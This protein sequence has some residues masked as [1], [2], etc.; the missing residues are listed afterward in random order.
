MRLSSTERSISA[1]AEALELVSG[2]ERVVG[3][4]QLAAF[5]KSFGTL[6]M[7]NAFELAGDARRYATVA[8]GA[9]DPNI[10][11]ADVISL[12]NGLRHILKANHAAEPA[13]DL[14]LLINLLQA[15][16]ANQCDS[17]Y[18][19]PMLN[20]LRR[21]FSGYGSLEQEVAEFITM[22][23]NDIG[24]EAFDGR[25]TNLARS[26]L[27][28]EQVVQ[29]ATQVYGTIPRSTSRKAALAFIRKPHDAYMSAKRGIDA[30]GGRSA[31]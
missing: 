31:A 21:A 3:L 1:Y 20:T 28:R 16:D 2:P 17:A 4:R 25:F 19:A 6:T 10:H 14:E 30:M 7:A 22:L 24:T 18:L 9:N 29:I 8:E 27:K 5:L 15:G 12:L 11:V 26:A 23:K 13:S